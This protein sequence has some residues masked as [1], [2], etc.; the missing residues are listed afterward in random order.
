M[1]LVSVKLFESVFQ[2]GAVAVNSV[3]RAPAHHA[4]A[5]RGVDCGRARV[6]VLGVEDKER[7][8]YP[9]PRAEFAKLIVCAHV[10]SSNDAAAFVFV[11][12]AAIEDDNVVVLGLQGVADQVGKRG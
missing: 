8:R 11:G 12:I 6:R 3:L 5:E 9:E 1:G 7:V 2:N 4:P 10:N